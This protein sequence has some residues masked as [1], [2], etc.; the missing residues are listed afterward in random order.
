MQRGNSL[1]ESFCLRP[2]EASGRGC[3]GPPVDL[4][5]N[6]TLLKQVAE[7]LQLSDPS[8]LS[9]RGLLRDA[10]TLGKRSRLLAG[11]AHDVA[12]VGGILLSRDLPC[13]EGT[14]EKADVGSD[15]LLSLGSRAA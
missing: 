14:R 6:R 2:V 5:I 12:E 9:R 4:G 7:P 15:L 8:L 10:G 1:G 13:L 11:T 3:H